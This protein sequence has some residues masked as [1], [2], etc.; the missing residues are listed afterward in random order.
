MKCSRPPGRGILTTLPS[1]VEIWVMDVNRS[2]TLNNGVLMPQVG[3]G[4]Y[5]SA[6]GRETQRAVVWALAAGYRHI[7]TASAYRN[8][9]DV[10]IGLQESGIPRREIFITT[11]LA[12]ADHGY[13]SALK[14]FELSLGKLK[15]DKVDLYL[16]HWPGSP[17]RRNSW[18]ALERIYE[19]K[20]ARAIGVSNYTIKHLEE[21]L[22]HCNVPPMVN[23]VE[24]SPFLYQRELFDFC[25][26][27][28]I[29]LEAYAPLTQGK[30]LANQDVLRI[31]AKHS[32]TPAQVLL[33][34]AMDLGIVVIPK[35]VRQD[36][37]EGNFTV[38]DLMLDEG[39]HA[40][41]GS[42]D[43]GLRTCWDPSR[44]P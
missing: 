44:I 19:Q 32:R 24:F 9:Q 14:A 3:L 8:E 42:L 27:H 41:L 33:R 37:I 2:V 16:I 35:S 31:A 34:W 22:A 17:E 1:V 5:Q 23:Q 39:D 26:E 12:R 30:R 40:T 20:L 4:V 18:K 10:A 11:K 7:D 38:W 21:L 13:E 36:R 28:Q 29:Q 25:T 43:E 15:I 6:P